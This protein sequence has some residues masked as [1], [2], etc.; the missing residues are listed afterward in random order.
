MSENNDDV[1]VEDTLQTPKISHSEELNVVKTA[2]QYFPQACHQI[3]TKTVAKRRKRSCPLCLMLPKS[4]YKTFITSEK[5]QLQLEI[6]VQ[7]SSRDKHR[8][9]ATVLQKASWPSGVTVWM[10]I[11]SQSL[12]KSFFAEPKT[13]TDAK[14]YQ[15]KVLKQMIE[16]SKRV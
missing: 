2:L 9:D 4:R 3:S 1:K 16:E 6:K 13:N 11:S 7:Y 14:C 12:T 8:K 10:E 15:N 5:A